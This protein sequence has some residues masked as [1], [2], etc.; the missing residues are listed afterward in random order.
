MSHAE[1]AMKKYLAELK[2]CSKCPRLV[3]SRK[4]VLGV[5]HHP[6]LPSGNPDSRIL[7]LGQAPGRKPPQSKE[8]LDKPFAQGSGNMLDKMLKYANLSR[9]KV[10]V[11]NILQCNTPLNGKFTKEEIT[12]C[13]VH[14]EKIS[15]IMQ[16]KIVITL[17]KFAEFHLNKSIFSRECKIFHVWHPAFIQRKRSALKDYKK[18]WDEIAKAAKTISNTRSLF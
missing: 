14:L 5:D 12:N 3:E 6:I 11:A 1:T 17:G 15:E 4:Q 7:I 2:L 13:R 18:Q 9:N 8:M 10:F 16:P